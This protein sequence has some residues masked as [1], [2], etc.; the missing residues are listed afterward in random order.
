MVSRFLRPGIR[1]SESK[2]MFFSKKPGKRR[3]NGLKKDYSSYKL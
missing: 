1:L 2:G 3:K